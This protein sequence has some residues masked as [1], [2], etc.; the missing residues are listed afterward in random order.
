M[1]VKFRKKAWERGFYYLSLQ[2]VFEV[3]DLER[4]AQVDHME[5]Y[6]KPRTRSFLAFVFRSDVLPTFPSNPVFLNIVYIC[7]TSY[8]YRLKWTFPLCHFYLI[9][10]TE[11]TQARPFLKQRVLGSCLWNPFPSTFPLRPALLYQ[12]G[13]QQHP[14]FQFL[15]YYIYRER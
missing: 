10:V 14:C 6:R 1:G 15:V 13:K 8:L 4:I 9:G 2:E 12:L 7:D 11:K 5:F 3:C